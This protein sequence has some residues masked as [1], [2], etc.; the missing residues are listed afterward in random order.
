VR[1]SLTTEGHTATAHALS[2]QRA[3]R[4]TAAVMKATGNPAAKFMH[5]LPA[6]H[7]TRPGR[8]RSHRRGLRIPRLMVATIPLRETNPMRRWPAVATARALRALLRRGAGTIVTP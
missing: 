3:Y 4:V 8:T 1:Y 5:C 2:S 6:L 7:K